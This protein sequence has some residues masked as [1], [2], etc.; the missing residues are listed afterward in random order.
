[1]EKLLKEKNLRVTPARLAL[2]VEI[3]KFQ[4]AMPFSAIQDQLKDMD[5]ITLFRTLNRL[6]EYGVIHKA[7]ISGQETYYALCAES[8]SKKA[9]HHNHVHFKCLSCDTVTCQE[10]KEEIELSI[11]KF[12]ISRVDVNVSGYCDQCNHA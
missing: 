6:L 11:P 9:H 4:S 3:Q 7:F 8:C 10:V 2:L 12:K 1:M 5:R